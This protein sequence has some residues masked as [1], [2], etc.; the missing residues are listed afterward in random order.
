VALTGKPSCSVAFLSV[1]LAPVTGGVAG[2]PLGVLFW[3]CFSEQP[4]RMSA[5][6]TA[7]RERKRGTAGEGS[8]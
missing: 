1:D 5:A 3:L 7:A 6:R 2:V 8:G 4:L